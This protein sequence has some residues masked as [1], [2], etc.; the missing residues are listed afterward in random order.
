MNSVA[1]ETRTAELVVHTGREDIDVL[2]DIVGDEAVVDVFHTHEQVIVLEA[3]RP[4]RRNGIF[5]ASADRSA[6]AAV[7]DRID[8]TKRT[9][10][11]RRVLVVDNSSTA[12]HVEQRTIVSIANLASE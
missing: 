8:T 6:P 10:S 9:G 1:G 3:K 12:V 5:E 7:V 11:D 4:A 2:L